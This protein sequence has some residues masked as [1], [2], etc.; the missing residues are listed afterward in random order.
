MLKRI[1]SCLLLSALCLSSVVACAGSGDPSGAKDTTAAPVVTTAP[2]E[3]TPPETT[4]AE[5]EPSDGLEDKNME[6]FEF[7]ILHCSSDSLNWALVTLDVEESNGELIND[8]IF[9]RNMTMEERFNMTIKVD[10]DTHGTVNS[11]YKTLVMSGDNPYDIIM[12][13]GIY[14]LKS[15]SYQAD[16]SVIP[17]INYDAAW[18]NPNATSE[19]NIGGKQVAAAGNFSLSYA[20]TANCLLFNKRMYD[21]LNTGEN[22]YDLVRNGKWTVDKF[23]E[24]ATSAIRDVNGDTVIG[25]GD[26]SG[27]TGTVKAMNH[28]LVIGAGLHYLTKDSEGFPV[29]AGSA[30]EKL[31]S[32]LEKII[33]LQVNQPAAYVQPNPKD[34]STL[35][36]SFESGECLFLNSWPQ[37]IASGK[38]SLRNM[39]DD[40]GILPPPKYDEA[41]EKYYCNMANGEVATLPRT[42]DPDR[43]D[44]IGI[45]LEAMSFY[46]HHKIIP[47]YKDVLLDVKVTRDEDSP[48]MLDYIFDGITYDFAINIWQDNVGNRIFTNEI[49]IPL[50]TNIVSTIKTYERLVQMEIK[51]LRKQIESMP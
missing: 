45:L 32:F 7:S 39:K 19:F 23:F 9:K 2:S 41:Q 48:E 15:L 11:Q 46:T 10:E 16:M 3:T 34:S 38:A 24:T 36:I 8:A 43:L 33:N 12:Q 37:N 20:S 49:Y 51:Q 29:F 5:T 27:S 13:Y 6:G 47:V 44:N 26:I 1:L 35:A 18:W 42:Y 30:D 4:P 22:L 28:M 14:S 17:H 50:N 25:A 31:V 40:F 21:E